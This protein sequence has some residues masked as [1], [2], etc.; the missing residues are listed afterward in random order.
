MKTFFMFY[1]Y[2][3]IR[4]KKKVDDLICISFFKQVLPHWIGPAYSGLI[5]LTACLFT[6]NTKRTKIK[7]G[8]PTPI[9][10]SLFFVLFISM[11]GIILINFYTGTLGSKSKNNI[12]DGDFTLDMYGWNTIKTDVNKLTVAITIKKIVLKSSN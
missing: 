2:I 7:F 3:F 6:K 9:T 8:L 11:A 10:I 1:L 12:G 5:L 4:N